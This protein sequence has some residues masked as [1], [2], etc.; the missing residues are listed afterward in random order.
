[1]SLHEKDL[2][3]VSLA[4]ETKQILKDYGIVL[5]RKLGQN[6]LIDDFK[7]KKILNFANLNSYDTVL[8][9]GPGI[10]TLT[11]PMASVA[12]KVIAIEQDPRIAQILNNRLEEIGLDNVEIINSDA[13]KV[14]FPHFNKI[15]SNLPYQIS[16]PITFKFLEYDFDLAILMYQKEFAQRMNAQV[17]SPHY[18]RL[19]V[20]IHFKAIVELLDNV[21]PQSFIPPPKV[22]SSVVKLVPLKEI[23]LDD[24]FA[25]VVRALFQH[26]RKK[27][28]KALKESFHEIGEFKKEEINNI[29]K[30][31]DCY[32]LEDRVFKLSP[33]DILGI[34]NRLN[35]ILNSKCFQ[36]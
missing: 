10:G 17:D 33:K 6:Y 29:L 3:T 35:I 32:L 24:F 1:M 36:I 18:S 21:S 7:R 20:M 2:G 12:K 11:F 25:S 13:L 34:S 28:K 9:I 30:K 23:E 26:R 22:D 15:V 27:A 8:E 31:M 14:D 16:S 4:Q 19:S 5:N